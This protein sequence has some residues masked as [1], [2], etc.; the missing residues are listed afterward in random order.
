[1]SLMTLDDKGRGLMHMMMSSYLFRFSLTYLNV[2]YNISDL[3]L[4]AGSQV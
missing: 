3:M 1:M 4:N 2:I